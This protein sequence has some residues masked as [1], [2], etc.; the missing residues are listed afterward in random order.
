M[1][2]GKRKI[3]DWMLF[4]GKMLCIFLLVYII[5]SIFFSWALVNGNSM[6]PVIADR[7]VVLVSK[8]SKEYQRGDIVI[9]HSG[10][11]TGKELIKRV[12]GI[13]G[14]VIEI[15]E[16]T[17]QVRVNG[18]NLWEPYIKE[19]TCERGDIHYPAQV[20]PGQYFVMGDNRNDSL[21]SRFSE[22]GTLPA[23]NIEGRVTVRIFPFTRIQRFD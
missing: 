12:I 18:E 8:I 17:H 11:G 22:V 1:P 20:P 15:D 21:D 4:A 5:R 2:N 14:D 23:E 9:C 10:K 19:E 6:N 3:H 7:D 13:P 16:N